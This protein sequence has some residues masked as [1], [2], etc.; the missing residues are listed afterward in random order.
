MKK[1]YVVGAGEM[2]GDLTPCEDDL[3]IAADGG[4]AHLLSLGI[5]PD[6]IVGD[7]DSVAQSVGEVLDI[8]STSAVIGVDR[9]GV[10]YTATKCKIEGKMVEIV[11][12]PVE[13]DETDTYLAYLI[14]LSRGYSEFALYGGV[15]GREDHTFAN[16]CLLLRIK[17]EKNNATLYGNGVK[18]FVLKNEKAEIHGEPGATVSVFAFGTV[19]EGVSIQ[20][21]KYEARDVSLDPARP[22]GVSNSFLSSGEGEIEVKDGALLVAI[23]F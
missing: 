21:L 7:F 14:G 9:D 20:G 6:V 3:V 15:G 16:L 2:H 13:K 4:V 12:Y 8:D 11:K 18:F 17:N 23:Y 19:A 1:C 22:L 10:S 5:T